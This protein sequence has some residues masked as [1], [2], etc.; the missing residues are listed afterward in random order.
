M[1][2]R[3]FRARRRLC[4]FM[5]WDAGLAGYDRDA[6]RAHCTDYAFD[7]SGT[8]III[9]GRVSQNSKPEAKSPIKIK[10]LV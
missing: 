5:N 10:H 9:S 2:A 4:L 3:G 7:P 8:D 1:A 6:R